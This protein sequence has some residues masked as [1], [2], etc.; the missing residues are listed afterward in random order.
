MRKEHFTLCHEAMDEGKFFI[1]N[2][3]HGFKSLN[4]SLFLLKSLV[5]ERLD[6]SVRDC[7]EDIGVP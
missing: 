4:L 7:I 2:E 6:S 5:Q 3:W 1:H